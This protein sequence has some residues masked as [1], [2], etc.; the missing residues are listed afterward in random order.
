M[1]K[2]FFFITISAVLVLALAG[3]GGSNSTNPPAQ[4]N[5]ANNSSSVTQPEIYAQ[6][7]ADL[8]SLSQAIQQF[9]T[10]EGRN[11]KDLQELTPNY[12]ARIPDAPAGYKINYDANSGA[13][14]LMQ[15]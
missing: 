5:A 14:S 8:A 7:K 2:A 15:Q 9:K 12:I 3:C 11:P 1:M 4:T 6:K 13:V 10:A